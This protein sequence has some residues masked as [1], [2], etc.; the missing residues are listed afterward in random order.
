MAL[1]KRSRSATVVRRESK[2]SQMR[3]R[4]ASE[5]LALESDAA[6]IYT[7]SVDQEVLLFA[8]DRDLDAATHIQLDLVP[9]HALPLDLT[10][11]NP[12][13]RALTEDLRQR[14]ARVSELMA[15]G[16]LEEGP[17]GLVIPHPLKLG[18]KERAELMQVVA[19]V[20]DTRLVLFDEL[21]RAHGGDAKAIGRLCGELWRGLRSPVHALRR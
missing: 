16:A 9:V 14:E 2:R 4:P 12:A 7:A 3:R 6:V 5:P 13:T 8:G 18:L 11:T 10:L 1:T 21:A 17:D 19:A 20:N 15:A